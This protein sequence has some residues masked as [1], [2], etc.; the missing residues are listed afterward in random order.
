MLDITNRKLG[1]PS[2]QCCMLHSEDECE[3]ERMES[4]LVSSSQMGGFDSGR[5]AGSGPLSGSRRG[6]EAAGALCLTLGIA[7]ASLF[8]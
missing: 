7:V 2:L 4:N 5:W 1:N 3:K 6:V 8:V